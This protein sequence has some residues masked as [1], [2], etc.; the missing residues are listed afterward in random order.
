MDVCSQTRAK[1]DDG[2]NRVRRSLRR[3]RLPSWV[4]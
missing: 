4:L 3:D 2:L 1:A